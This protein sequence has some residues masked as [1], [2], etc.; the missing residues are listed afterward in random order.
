MK[1]TAEVSARHSAWTSMPSAKAGETGRD[2]MWELPG[3][4]QGTQHLNLRRVRQSSP[5]HQ[6]IV[7]GTPR[8]S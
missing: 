3:R 4:L 1:G 5:L 8:A 7:A 6:T 2:T